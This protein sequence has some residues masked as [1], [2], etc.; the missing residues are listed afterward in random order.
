MLPTRLNMLS[1]EKQR[2]LR[3][4][5]FVQFSKSILQTLIFLL[6][7]LS[8]FLLGGQWVMQEHFNQLAISATQSAHKYTQANAQIREINSRIEN[9]ERLFKEYVPYTQEAIAFFNQIP[10]GIELTTVTLDFRQPSIPITGVAENR[11]ALLQLESNLLDLPYVESAEIPYSL[12]LSEE[13][14]NFSLKIDLKESALNKKK[15]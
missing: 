6:S 13:N 10:E 9:T 11:E 3:R 8:I 5:L 4:M 7:L 14:V 2:F 1:K 15:K 12:L